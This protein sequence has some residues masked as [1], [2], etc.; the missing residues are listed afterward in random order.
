MSSSDRQ[1]NWPDWR[2]KESYD[3]ARALSRRA[4]AWE[5]LRRN[6]EFQRT[7]ST[8]RES[9]VVERLSRHLTL[10][11]LTAAPTLLHQWGA[12]FHGRGRDRCDGRRCVLEPAG[13]PS[14]APGRGLSARG[15][16]RDEAAAHCRLAL[17]GP[18]LDWARRSAAC[19]VPRPWMRPPVRR[20]RRQRLAP[21]SVPDRSTG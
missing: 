19:P 7:C 5:F 15:G 8:V 4:W 1:G 13:L 3:Y 20:F 21:G 12:I 10:I 18:R 6:P 9:A 2:R 17:S 14:R 11:R 16:L